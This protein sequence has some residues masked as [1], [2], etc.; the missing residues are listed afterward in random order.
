M[1]KR[2][3]VEYDTDYVKTY[4][5]NLNTTLIFVRYPI[6]SRDLSHSLLQAGLFSAVSSAFVVDVHSNPT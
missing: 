3:A 2:E 1:Y 5:E 6:S 4:D